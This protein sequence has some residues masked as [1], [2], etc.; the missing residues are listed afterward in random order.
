MAAYWLYQRTTAFAVTR[1]TDAKPALWVTLGRRSQH[2]HRRGQ[3][4]RFQ[5]RL[6]IASDA[7]PVWI[8]EATGTGAHRMEGQLR[9][10]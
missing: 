4:L 5:H 9:M 6:F 1:A 10:R 2:P 8:V 7:A 3:L